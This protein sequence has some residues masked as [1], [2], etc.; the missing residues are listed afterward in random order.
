V[1]RPRTPIGTFGD[2]TYVKVSG[3]QVRARTRYRDD[4]GQV[5]RVSATGA[6]NKEAER[7]LKKVLSQRP[8]HVASG[9]LTDDTSFGKLVEVWLEDLDL[10]N[11][12]APGTRA[13][14]M[15]ML[16]HCWRLGL[17][18]PKN[19]EG[20]DDATHDG[21]ADETAGEC[22]GSPSSTPRGPG[23]RLHRRE[24][25]QGCGGL[26]RSPATN[27]RPV[28]GAHRGPATRRVTGAA[29]RSGRTT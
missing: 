27:H 5:R 19:C 29:S 22:V 1:G 9:Q 13:L 11:K 18:H 14:Y 24:S 12:L 21:G 26:M 10:E 25:H 3:A 16:P 2:I 28:E 20:C 7:N 6:T 4:D 17:R 8:S 15:C 23:M